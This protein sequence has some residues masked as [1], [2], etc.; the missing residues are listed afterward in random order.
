MKSNVRTKFD[1]E[2][3][4][5]IRTLQGN[6][7]DLLTGIIPNIIKAKDIINENIS[8]DLIDWPIFTDSLIKNSSFANTIFSRVSIN[9]CNIE[10]SDFSKSIHRVSNIS[11]NIIKNTLFEGIISFAP[12]G[13][14]N[15]Y[16]SNK[17]QDV[18][19][20]NSDL[21]KFDFSE[22]SF[23]N[24]KFIKCIM[25][26]SC[27]NDTVLVNTDFSN[28][29]LTRSKFI[30]STLVNVKFINADLNDSKFNYKD[31][32]GENVTPETVLSNVDF[33]NAI[34]TNSNL[35]EISDLN[36]IILPPLAIEELID[37][38]GDNINIEE[39]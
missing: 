31:V 2:K 34:I 25:V 22:S 19:F 6:W 10:N 16:T 7:P 39:Y 1:R 8:N 21:T 30:K 35:F 13:L 18:S 29:D 38:T 5:E 11:N 20:S 14:G 26:G 33:T 9:Y 32:K 23:M 36:N 24:V 17:F 4:N 28:S 15:R 3:F 37:I 12:N 27:F